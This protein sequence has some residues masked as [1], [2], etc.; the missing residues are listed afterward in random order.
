MSWEV[1]T[2]LLDLKELESQIAEFVDRSN[3]EEVLK[4]QLAEFEMLQSMFSN[5]GELNVDDHSVLADFNNYLEGKTTLIPPQLDFTINLQ[6]N[7]NKLEVCV[8]L[9]LEYPNL[10]PDIFVR[11]ETL[12]RNQQ[13]ALNNKFAEYVSSLERGE[14]CICLAISW[15]QENA[16]EYFD[17]TN[18]EISNEILKPSVQD[19]EDVFNR[20]WIYSH[21]IYSKTKRREILDL[22]NEYNVTGFCMPGRPGIICVEGLASDCEKWWYKVNKS[23]TIIL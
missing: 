19:G 18:L 12:N 5:P 7:S 21:H 9:P 10:E 4:I 17:N 16:L 22:A 20:L 6:L 13:H 3:V 8:N 1:D 23:F 11:S 15:L 2:E 14:I